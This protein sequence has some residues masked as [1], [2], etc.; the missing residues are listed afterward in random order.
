MPGSIDFGQ[1]F[2]H[3]PNAYM[4]LD[5]ELRFVAA[6]RAY[7]EVTSSRLDALLGR[8]VFDVFP[9]R[10]DDPGRE[11]ERVLRESFA[12]VLESGKPHVIALIRYRVPRALPDGTVVDADRFWSATHSPLADEHGQVRY[13]VQHTVD[14]TELQQLKAAAIPPESHSTPPPQLEQGVLGRA[15]QVQRVNEVLSEEREL[16]RQLFAQAPG[17]VCF[18]RGPDHLFELANP[19][20]EKLLGHRNFL[21]KTVR[22][23]VPEA[24]GQGFCELLDR[25]YQ[26]G[27]PYVGHGV[28]ILLEQSPG[29]PPE[30]RFLDFVY[31]PITDASRRVAG[32]FVQG[33]DIT[34]Q[35]RAESERAALLEAERAARARAEAAEKQQR[36]LAEAIPQQVWTAAPD[37][38]LDFV[39]ER[40]VDYF[41]TSREQILGDGW[42]GVI[43]PEDLPRAIAVWTRALHTGEEYEVQF[44][45]RRY[46]GAWR[47]HL[48][49]ARPMRDHR[50]AIV[51]WYGTNTDVDEG[52]RARDE[53]EERARF[54]QQLI[55]I[56][57]HDLRNPL[58][59][60]GVAAALLLRRGNLDDQQGKTV[61]RMVSLVE[62]TGRMIRDF[63]DFTQARSAGYIPVE[64]ARANLREITR[65]VV[66]EVHLSHPDREVVVEH[67][68]EDTGRWDPD[69]IAQVVGN[70]VANAFQHS[71]PPAL[72]RVSSKVEE[73]RAEIVVQ[74]D[75]PPIPEA[76]LKRLFAPFQRG[77]GARATTTRS[78]GLGLY[79]TFAIVAAH[80]GNIEVES[81]AG[82]G[83]RFTVRLPRES[84]G[85]TAGRL[86]ALAAGPSP[87]SPSSPR[88]SG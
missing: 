50:G 36:F 78:V 2:E 28:K 37:G 87:P 29:A 48:A 68:G 8:H 54:E 77:E 73:E 23:A 6:N 80:G 22:E 47:W 20:Y 1:L 59:A 62:R 67:H 15:R 58:N 69:R 83:T 44:R 60:I 81:S 9:D 11:N 3:S 24:E 42:Q 27:V 45:L 51:R 55:G 35:M 14:V 49:R 63:L 53:L 64:P 13:L 17:F 52:T 75:G 25:V 16:L 33:S 12:R 56:V 61:G 86:R 10:S 46:D 76:D 72:V 74:N 19:A 34:A 32:I 65:E 85:P 84:P 31:Q 88:S 79:I 7:L 18:L 5:R 43:H 30:E 70:L 40:V 71:Q 39:S 57:S 66:D 21:G 41:G 82:R 4:V 26:T 38:R